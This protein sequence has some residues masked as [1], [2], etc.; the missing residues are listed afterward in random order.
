MHQQ[1]SYPTT[2][3]VIIIDSSKLP[4]YNHIIHFPGSFS[5]GSTVKHLR[6]SAGDVGLIPE[7]GRFPGEGN[8]NPLQ[9]SWK[10]WITVFPGIQYSWKIPWIEESGRLY[11]PWVT[12]S[13]T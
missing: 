3:V 11:S 2:N 9:Y 13:Q 1:N 6:A 8:G 7:S 5:G 10:Y 4:N 12:K